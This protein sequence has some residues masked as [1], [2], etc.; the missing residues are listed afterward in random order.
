MRKLRKEHFGDDGMFR[1]RIPNW[2]RLI[3]SMAL[4]VKG[5]VVPM[6]PGP[7]RLSTVRYVKRQTALRQVDIDI[8]RERARAEL[9]LVNFNR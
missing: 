7:A 2:T 1:E 3:G 8:Q 5:L 6:I 9:R 4:A